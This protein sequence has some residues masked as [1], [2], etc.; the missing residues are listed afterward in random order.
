MQDYT[1]EIKRTLCQL[2][3]WALIAAIGAWAAG[4]AHWIP[5]LLTGVGAS[6]LYYLQMAYRVRK[7]ADMPISKA[8]NYMRVGWLLRLGFLLLILI[9][10]VHTTVIHFWAAVTGLFSLQMIMVLNAV[11]L[12]WKTHK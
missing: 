3:V 1:L 10:S 12:A 2:A 5:G 7:T 9:L 8:V 11:A 4:H 6:A